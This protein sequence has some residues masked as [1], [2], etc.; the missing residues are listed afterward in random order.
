MR[1]VSRYDVIHVTFP[2]SLESPPFQ[3]IQAL[4]EGCCETSFCLFSVGSSALAQADQ[5]AKR[6]NKGRGAGLFD[7][8]LDILLFTCMIWPKVSTQTRWHR[9]RIDNAGKRLMNM[10]HDI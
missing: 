7:Q 2:I 1:F 6:G 8:V 3:V 10:I 4:R 5:R 9:K